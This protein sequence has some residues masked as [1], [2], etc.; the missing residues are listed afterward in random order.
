[1]SNL[2]KSIITHRRRGSGSADY[3]VLEDRNPHNKTGERQAVYT[4]LKA[5]RKLARPL[6]SKLVSLGSGF[7]ATLL[8]SSPAFLGLWQPITSC[9]FL[10]LSIIGSN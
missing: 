9:V 10:Q 3:Q 1:M 5:C 7:A 6:K 8:S 2:T 4:G